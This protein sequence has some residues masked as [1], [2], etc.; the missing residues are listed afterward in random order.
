MVPHQSIFLLCV[1]Y[2][3]RLIMGLFRPFYPQFGRIGWPS[4]DSTSN[5][6]KNEICQNLKH[7]C[8]WGM[9]WSLPFFLPWGLARPGG[10]PGNL[11]L[12]YRLSLGPRPHPLCRLGL[13]L[14]LRLSRLP[15]PLFLFPLL[16]LN[17]G[18]RLEF[19]PIS[20]YQSC[21]LQY[22]FYVYQEYT[23]TIICQKP[24]TAFQLKFTL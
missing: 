6:K 17:P 1:S 10:N 2:K 15:C 5:V 14:Q 16:G 9:R 13:S 7:A 12:C 18:P 8:Q 3:I 19:L 4:P 21:R 11:R 23:H 24:E 22:N 20:L